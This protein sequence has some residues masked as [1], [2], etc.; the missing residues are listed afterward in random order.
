MERRRR[1]RARPFH[2]GP[3]PRPGR[4]DLGPPLRSPAHL[5]R[6]RRIPHFGHVSAL[7]ITAKSSLAHALAERLICVCQ[8]AQA[9]L[10]PNANIRRAAQPAAATP[11]LSLDPRCMAP[12]TARSAQAS[13]P[14]LDVAV[15]DR[16]VPGEA[17]RRTRRCR[18]RRRRPVSTCRQRR[19]A[20]ARNPAMRPWITWSVLPHIVR[21]WSVSLSRA[22]PRESY[23]P[24]LGKV[25]AASRRRYGQLR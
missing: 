7:T 18:H 11:A 21:I 13:A 5:A 9:P 25:L 6:L 22:R 15:H 1:G 16:D 3:E 17:T 14:R 19:G 23:C 24:A 12:S 4:W 8:Q 10:P 2:A 20:P